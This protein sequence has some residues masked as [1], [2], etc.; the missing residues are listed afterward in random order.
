MKTTRVLAYRALLALIALG[1]DACSTGASLPWAPA[2][3]ARSSPV[4]LGLP[5]S[6]RLSNVDQPPA[7]DH[8][9]CPSMASEE[10]LPPGHPPLDELKPAAGARGLPSDALPR[11]AVAPLEWRAPARWQLIANKSAMRLASY[12]V[13]H[14]SGDEED[15]E[16]SVVQAGGSVRANAERWIGQFDE[17]GQ[18]TAKLTSRRVGPFDVTVVEVQGT[19]AGGMGME[20]SPRSGWAMLGAI[21]PTAGTPFFFKLTGPARSVSAA[22]AEFDS[23]VGSLVAR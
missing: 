11:E 23:L 4:A 9:A 22:G 6:D 20:Q 7:P 12:R 16:L 14:A 15:A 3:P 2:R 19:Y 13:P 8:A 10:L 18:K 5:R 17:A 1:A 21:V